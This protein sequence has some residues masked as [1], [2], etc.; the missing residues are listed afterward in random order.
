MNYSA[1]CLERSFQILLDLSELNLAFDEVPPCFLSFFILLA[2]Y[3]LL[4]LSMIG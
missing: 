4:Q 1:F 3:H 2:R